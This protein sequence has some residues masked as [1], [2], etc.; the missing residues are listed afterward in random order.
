MEKESFRFLSFEELKKG[1]YNY[2][3]QI[4]DFAYLSGKSID[5]DKVNYNKFLK[6][7]VEIINPLN[8]NEIRNKYSIP[9]IFK[10]IRL[11]NDNLKCYD[12]DRLDN[13]LF[14]VRPVIKVISEELKE[15]INNYLG[16]VIEYGEYPQEKVGMLA[17]KK[18]EYL[19]K[20]NLLSQTDKVYFNFAAQFSNELNSDLILNEY[21]YNDNKYVR[22][23]PCNTQEY[24]WFKVSPIKWVID[25]KNNLVL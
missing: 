18:L 11:D 14:G 2:P 3:Y 12:A 19:Y 17:T 7:G 10:S 22:F 1:V 6:Y 13:K 9:V 8:I 21:E 4:S 20:K 16:D 23:N 15:K 5:K 24:L 25:R